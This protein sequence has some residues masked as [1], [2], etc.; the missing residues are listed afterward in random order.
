MLDPTETEEHEIPGDRRPADA[1]TQPC[2][3]G[4]RIFTH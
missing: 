2:C 1:P 4:V 3:V